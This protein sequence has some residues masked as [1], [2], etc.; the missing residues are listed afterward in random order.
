[1]FFDFKGNE[2]ITSAS[3]SFENVC[4]VANLS[5]SFSFSKS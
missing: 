5:A 3:S 4:S 2:L 1:M